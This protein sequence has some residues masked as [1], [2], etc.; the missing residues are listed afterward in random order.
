[1]LLNRIRDGLDYL[2]RMISRSPASFD[3]RQFAGRYVALYIP[4]GYTDQRGWP[5]LLML[6]GCTQDAGDFAR[7]TRMN[8]FA[9]HYGMIVAYPEQSEKANRKRCWNWFD[10]ANQRRGSGELAELMQIV[11]QLCSDYAI[12]PGRIYVAGISAGACLAVALAASYPEAFAA[13]GS[14]AGLE[15]RAASNV[16]S[17]LAAMRMRRR[18][19]PP[20]ALAQPVPLV[21]FHGTGDDV[22]QPLNSER[23]VQQWVGDRRVQLRE[24]DGLILP[25]EW[26]GQRRIQRSSYYL[27]DG[28]LLVQRYLVEGTPHAWP[29]GSAAGSFTDPA[30]PDASA[31]MV[32]F[33]LRHRIADPAAQSLKSKV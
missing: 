33:F 24:D 30:G 25:L 4:G 3:A 29:G 15:Y 32:D 23:L 9:E 6:H 8:E 10:S 2:R 17:G 19:R 16:I 28:R 14:V 5:L 13:V 20:V 27:G 22:I 11:A 7:G 1:L 31:I 12:D 21:L 26:R 18:R